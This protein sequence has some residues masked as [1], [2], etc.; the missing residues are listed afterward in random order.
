MNIQTEEVAALK[1]YLQDHGIGA[2]SIYPMIRGRL[3][4]ING[5]PVEPDTYTDPRARR[6]VVRLHLL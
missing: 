6:M 1:A 4:R 2:S 5:K 3:T